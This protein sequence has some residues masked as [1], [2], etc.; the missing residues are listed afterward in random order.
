MLAGCRSVEDGQ[1]TI[2][3]T[4]SEVRVETRR[5]IVGTGENLH[6]QHGEELVIRDF[7]QDRRDGVFLDVGAAWPVYYNNTY[8]LESELGWS[9]VAVD[10][11]AEHGKRWRNRRPNSQFFTYIVTDHS[12][13]VETF[14]R[15]KEG[16]LIGISTLSPDQGLGPWN[17]F[18]EVQVQTTTLTDLLEEAG[19]E[20]IDLLSM[21]IEGHELTA[22]SE[23][24]IERFKPELVCIEV[25]APARIPVTEYFESK[26]YRRLP[27]YDAYDFANY[28]FT[29]IET[30]TDE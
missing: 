16:E 20:Q 21:D 15:T 6:S 23:F 2:P 24:D 4:S 1:E 9:G 30:N 17:E 29:P 5:D 28:Y 19:V 3:D 26:G 14:Y 13:G 11:L 22:L 8:Y 27:Q 10:A 25:H 18:E 7:F 12:G